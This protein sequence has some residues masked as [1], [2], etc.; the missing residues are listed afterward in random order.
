MNFTEKYDFNLKNLLYVHSLEICKWTFC[1]EMLFCA[2]LR[3]HR[4]GN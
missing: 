3:G 1:N 4:F 2:L